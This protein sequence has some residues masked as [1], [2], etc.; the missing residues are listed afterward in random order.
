[1]PI[2][3]ILTMIKP[4]NKIIVIAVQKI[5]TRHMNLQYNYDSKFNQNNENDFEYENE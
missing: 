1:M 5:M 3:K 2:T 4:I